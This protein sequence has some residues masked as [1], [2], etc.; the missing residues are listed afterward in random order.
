M[1]TDSPARP[2][3]HAERGRIGMRSRW[4]ADAARRGLP[5]GP[6]IVRLDS[7]DPVTR[8]VIVSILRARKNAAAADAK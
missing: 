2:L 6:R 8:E 1:A 5:P 4:D 3:T 7:L